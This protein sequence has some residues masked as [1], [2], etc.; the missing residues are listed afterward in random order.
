MTSVGAF[1]THY[2]GTRWPTEIEVLREYERRLGV[3]ADWLSLGH[4][5]A[6]EDLHGVLGLVG[7]KKTYPELL[8][9][10]PFFPP[11]RTQ[12]SAVN[13]QTQEIAPYSS[14]ISQI[15]HIPIL[16]DRQ[17]AGYLSGERAADM[18]ED[19][20]PVTLDL[21]A[22]PRAF[23]YRVADSDRS[24]LRA[25]GSGFQP[26]SPLI[27]D[28][29]APISPGCYVLARLKTRDRY[30][31]RR[32]QAAFDHDGSQPFTLEAINTSF[33]AIRVTDPES[34]EIAG[35]VIL[36]LVAPEAI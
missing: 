14:I 4:G 34:W 26:G 23:S 22:G 7:D 21:K 29:D 24:M 36:V 25:N 35:R 3:P 1:Y 18:M 2:K 12:G 9:I 31:L 8:R 5:E 28:P 16:Q 17:I 20:I 32:Y 10:L 13:Q 30:M 11:P 19:T 33:E 15:R 6:I 27:I